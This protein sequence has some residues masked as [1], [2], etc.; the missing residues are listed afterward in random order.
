LSTVVKPIIMS[1]AE[2]LRAKKA[3]LALGIR[4]M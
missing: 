2:S 1:K 4:V 3:E